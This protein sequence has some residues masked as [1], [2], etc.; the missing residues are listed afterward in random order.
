V[1]SHAHNREA[2]YQQSRNGREVSPACGCGGWSATT[3]VGRGASGGP[4]QQRLLVLVPDDIRS[5]SGGVVPDRTAGKRLSR[6]TSRS[7][8]AEISNRTATVKGVPRPAPSGR[9][10][11]AEAGRLVGSR[12]LPRPPRTDT[13][14]SGELHGASDIVVAMHARAGGQASRDIVARCGSIFW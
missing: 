6:A 3:T 1:S 11:G 8:G 4:D 2:Q 14:G 7:N 10:H 5:W 9:V 13:D 12:A